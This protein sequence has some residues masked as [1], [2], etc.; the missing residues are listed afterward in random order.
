V[1]CWTKFVGRAELGVA[2]VPHV[3]V[4][5]YG[6]PLRGDDG[7]GWAAAAALFR[8]NKSPDVEVLPCHQLTPELASAM[9]GAE[10]VIFVDCA[11]EGSPGDFRCVEIRPEAGPGTFTHGLT[12]STL[13]SLTCELFGVCPHVYMLSVCGRCFE[14]GETL[15]PDVAAGLPELKRVLSELIHQHMDLCSVR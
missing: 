14:A 3:L 5:G 2:A 7:L 13:L 6:N 10:A 15:S 1:C 11:R 8:E 4:I 9:S 12:P